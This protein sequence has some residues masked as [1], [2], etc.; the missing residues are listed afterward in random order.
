MNASEDFVPP[1][2]IW[3]LKG[4]LEQEARLRNSRALIDLA[5][6]TIRRPYP[7]ALI[8]EF[9]E[10]LDCLVQVRDGDLW[11]D[12][13]YPQDKGRSS[14]REKLVASFYP[15]FQ[16]LSSS[17]IFVTAGSQVGLFKLANFLSG[18]P[19]PLKGAVVSPCYAAF[20]GA[21]VRAGFAPTLLAVPKPEH[22]CV[23]EL[24]L[25]P[26]TNFQIPS[27]EGLGLD[28]IYL[29][30]PNNPTGL[31][32]SRANMERVLEEASKTDMLVIVDSAYS[33]F[34]RE[35]HKFDLFSLPHAKECAIEV[36]TFSKL[37]GMAA[38]RIGWMVIPERTISERIVR[39]FRLD[40][41]NDFFSEASL[42]VSVFSQLAAEV[43][44]DGFGRE[45][46][47]NS[48]KDYISASSK[49]GH[50]LS[51]HGFKVAGGQDCPLLWV[52]DP[53]SQDPFGV[54]RRLLNDFGL[55]SNPSLVYT[56]GRLGSTPDA[57]RLTT[58]CSSSDLTTAIDRLSA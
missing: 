53:D 56:G 6:N 23:V 27:I 8:D 12:Y 54:M 37:A 2:D 48:T 49:I 40:L 25:S 58:M 50:L 32:V 24:I 43:Y 28:F 46:L 22:H 26:E 57:V 47:E 34:I 15:S 41:L 38:A 5:I 10:R 42:G 18:A 1:S 13:G 20:P 17:D 14:L 33:C 31:A 52:W 9:T 4:A 29:P 7:R 55:T 3:E 51:E 39:K 30:N 11:P 21:L 45:A 36:G 35:Q 16:E 44:L 19:S